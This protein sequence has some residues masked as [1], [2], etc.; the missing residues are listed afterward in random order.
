LEERRKNQKKE[1]GAAENFKTNTL[2]EVEIQDDVYD[3]IS[4]KARTVLSLKGKY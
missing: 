4:L 2:E 1:L 3:R